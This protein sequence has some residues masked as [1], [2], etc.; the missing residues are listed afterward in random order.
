[1]NLFSFKHTTRQS[2]LT[3]LI[4]IFGL[5]T[6][7]KSYSQSEK[8]DPDANR[9]GFID[10]NAYYDTRDASTLTINYLAV[11]NDKLSYFSFINFDQ[12]FFKEG[13]KTDFSSYYSEHNLTYFPIKNLPIGINTQAVLISGVKN[14]KLRFA[15]TWNVSDTPGISKFFKS[16][17][18]SWGINFHV[19]Q[20]QPKTESD[21]MFFQMEHFYRWNILG[22]KL[23][24]RLYLSG[25]ADHTLSG[26]NA[27]GLVTE[28]QLGYRVSNGFYIVA[29]YR[30]FSYFPKKYRDG[31]G[32]GLEY[33]I[34]FK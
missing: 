34:K 22:K 31:L 28:H 17:G 24:N 25:F 11:I 19:L 33:E 6:S 32:L 3:G 30:H 26:K 1:M 8:V 14:D 21:G 2:L 10:V 16:I 5:S 23:N 13:E 18:L 27:K 20:L 15:P 29:E 12:S 7:I 9:F 4:F